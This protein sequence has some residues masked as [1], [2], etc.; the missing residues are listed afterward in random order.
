M[1]SASTRTLDLIDTA[2][3]REIPMIVAAAL[4]RAAELGQPTMRE[5]L[6]ALESRQDAAALDEWAIAFEDWTIEDAEEPHG[7]T[8]G[9][10]GF[11]GNT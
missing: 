6:K 9:T 11:R 7:T 4:N 2:T 5:C 3:A 1:I 10:P 8:P